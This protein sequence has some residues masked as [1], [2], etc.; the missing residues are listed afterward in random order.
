[1]MNWS[2]KVLRTTFI[3]SVLAIGTSLCA[4]AESGSRGPVASEL[5]LTPAHLMATTG[6][7]VALQ[8]MFALYES[9]YAQ[10][11]QAA[12]RKWVAGGRNATDGSSHYGALCSR[13]QLRLRKGLPAG[14]MAATHSVYSH[15]VE[16]TR[17]VLRA[18]FES[19]NCAMA[20]HEATNL[21]EIEMLYLLE[22]DPHAL[23]C[24]KGMARYQGAQYP[25]DHLDLSGPSSDP[26]SAA[27]LLQTLSVG[28]RYNHSYIARE[29]W[30]S[31]WREAAATMVHRMSRQVQHNGKVVSLAHKNSGQGDEAFFMSAMLAAELLHWHG[32]VESQPIGFRLAQRILDRL[33]DEH[34]KRGT[35]CLPYTSKDARTCA[36]DLAGFH[37]WPALVLWQE[38]GDA[39]Y[40][41]FA[42]KNM[43]AAGSAFVGGAKQFNQ[44]YST[45]AQSAEAL[46]SGQRWR[47]RSES[48]TRRST[49]YRACV[50]RSCGQNRS[51]CEDHR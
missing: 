10:A 9:W 4:A 40:R 46:L 43:D 50:R 30:G 2:L 48:M 6:P 17:S 32:F 15:G 38:T 31:T 51:R 44:T 20:P 5:N 39:K 21:A 34:G 25:E 29:S 18:R 12:Y 47:G 49:S 42:L 37:V 14:L 24:I 11:E 45:G 36:S 33:M 19:N 1:M 16:M 41:D 26:R 22:G 7:L 35:A 23:E 13:Y 27:I 28:A 3:V 8:S